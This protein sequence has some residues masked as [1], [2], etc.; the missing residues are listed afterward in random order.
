MASC[1]AANGASY[2]NRSTNVRKAGDVVRWRFWKHNRGA[3]KWGKSRAV[4]LPK[5]MSQSRQ[6]LRLRRVGSRVGPQSQ[7]AR[8]GGQPVAGVRPGLDAAR[9]RTFGC[10]RLIQSEWPDCKCNSAEQA[11]V[12]QEHDTRRRRHAFCEGRWRSH[13]TSARAAGRRQHTRQR[14]RSDSFKPACPTTSAIN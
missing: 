8:N 3:K 10:R 6:P 4:S 11:R 7:L 5:Q 14:T 2:W 9:T 1:R 12:A 13:A